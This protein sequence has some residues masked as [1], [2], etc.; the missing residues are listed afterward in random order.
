MAQEAGGLSPSPAP[1]LS[2]SHLQR[3]PQRDHLLDTRPRPS[4][5]GQVIRPD[6]WLWKGTNAKE[7]ACGLEKGEITVS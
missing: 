2:L 7:Q 1:A 4:T 3:P 5:A 6:R